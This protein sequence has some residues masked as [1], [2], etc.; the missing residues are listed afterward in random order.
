MSEDAAQFG[1]VALFVILIVLV[2]GEPD[3]LD[4]LI[5]NLMDNC[6]SIP[7]VTE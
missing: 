6:Q 5:C 3:L 1:I 4:A 2:L 7:E